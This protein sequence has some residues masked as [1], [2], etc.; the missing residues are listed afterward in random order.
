M[1]WLKNKLFTH[2]YYKITMDG[3]QKSMME[4][5]KH[6]YILHIYND[7]HVRYHFIKLGQSYKLEYPTK[8]LGLSVMYNDVT[9]ILPTESFAIKHNEFNS[10]IQ[11]WLCKHYLHIA[12]QDDG[13]FTI[14]DQNACILQKKCIVF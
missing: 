12:P 6:D 1:Q 3:D 2:Q 13:Q 4:N 14:I 11:K 5:I 9:Y 7:G 8:I 10:T